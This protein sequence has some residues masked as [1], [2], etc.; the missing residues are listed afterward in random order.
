[1]KQVLGF[2]T[3]FLHS[4]KLDSSTQD[5]AKLDVAECADRGVLHLQAV[6]GDVQMLE[7]LHH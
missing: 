7:C 1:M 5:T 4:H 6:E 2:D 3:P